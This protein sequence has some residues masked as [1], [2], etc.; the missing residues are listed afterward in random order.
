MS[1]LGLVTLIYAQ[2]EVNQ[3]IL[4]PPPTLHPRHCSR[5]IPEILHFW[6]KQK[7]APGVIRFDHLR[8]ILREN[9]ESTMYVQKWLKKF[10]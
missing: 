9:F 6:N 7:N 4:I 3:I 8:T 1:P 10:L 5:P 2:S